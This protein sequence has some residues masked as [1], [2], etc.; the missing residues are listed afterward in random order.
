MV[1]ELGP[2]VPPLTA[3]TGGALRVH[4][5][6]DPFVLALPDLDDSIHLLGARHR[7]GNGGTAVAI[8]ADLARPADRERLVAEVAAG[9]GPIDVL[10]SNAAV[11]YFLPIR[12]FT[13]KRQ[14][15][16]FE[17]Q[18]AAPVHLAQLVLPGMARAG[19]G[20]I[21]N[22]SSGAAR[23]PVIPPGP[24]SQHR[25][26]DVRDVQGRSGAFHHRARR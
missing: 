20:W 18:V 3:R 13:A 16:M 25:R 7:A 8:A 26:D 4:H 15:L 17:V 24:V 11:T 10:V 2:T 1:V 21:L 6:V 5:A 9:L 23:H 22:I 14:Q 19:A 12:E